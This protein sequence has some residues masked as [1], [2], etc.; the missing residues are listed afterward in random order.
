M[1]KLMGKTIYNMPQ[2]AQELTQCVQCGYCIDVCEAHAQ[3]PWDSVTPRGKIYY[4]KQLDL[5]ALGKT[6]KLL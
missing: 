5:K 4:I 2:I 6:D 1:P 3:T